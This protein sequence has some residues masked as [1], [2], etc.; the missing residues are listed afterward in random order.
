MMLR[1]KCEKMEKNNNI[2]KETAF[3]NEAVFFILVKKS[4]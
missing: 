4:Y 1:M 3:K 2:K